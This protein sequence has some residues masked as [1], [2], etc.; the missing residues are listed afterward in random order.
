MGQYYT[1]VNL[2][3]SERIYSHAFGSGLKLMESCYV[4]N[5]Y[6]EAA[7]HLLAG[8]WKGDRVLYCGDYAWDDPSGSAG[9]R[10]HELSDRDPY[11]FAEECKD[12]STRFAA[13]EGNTRLE[14]F[15]TAGGGH[16]FRS[17]PLEGAFDIKPERYRYVVNETKQVYVDREKAP[18]TWV[19]AEGGDFGIVRIDPLPLLMAI[20]NGLGGGDYWGPNEGQVGSWAGDLIVPT[21]ERP[22]RGYQE[23]ASPFD[24]SGVFLT[25]RDDE[26]SKAIRANMDKLAERGGMDAKELVEK[27]GLSPG[28]CK[29]SVQDLTQKAKE[30][31]GE[32]NTERTN[33]LSNRSSGLGR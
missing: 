21:N 3:K 16:G 15:E 31:A 17:V 12:I 5:D 23:I 1:F 19:W 26:L 9:D 22:G 6:M 20:G 24:E 10:L 29:E 2:D 33:E 11:E 18:V 27:L 32:R 7:S 30:R 8:P 14:S 13:C 4:G 25:M 28:E